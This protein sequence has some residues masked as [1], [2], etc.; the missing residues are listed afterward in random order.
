MTF[1]SSV[2]FT[3]KVTFGNMIYGLRRIPMEWLNLIISNSFASVF[4]LRFSLTYL[5]IV[6]AVPV[7]HNAHLEDVLL[8][9]LQAM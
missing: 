3:D 2:L 7:G 8:T 4:G 5:S 6:S 9:I 1:L